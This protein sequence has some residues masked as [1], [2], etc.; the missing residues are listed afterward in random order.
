MSSN[1][2]SKSNEVVW[3]DS[4]AKIAMDCHMSNMYGILVHTTHHNVSYAATNVNAVQDGRRLCVST[5]ITIITSDGPLHG[6][7]R[8]HYVQMSFRDWL[9]P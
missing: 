3:P 6:M 2:S 5:I 8:F 7:S 4:R 9:T 1:L